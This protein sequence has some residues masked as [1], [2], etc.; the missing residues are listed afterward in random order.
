MRNL[1]EYTVHSRKENANFDCCRWMQ[2]KFAEV[3]CVLKP[4]AFTHIATAT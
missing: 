4:L 2:V 3:T 1:Q